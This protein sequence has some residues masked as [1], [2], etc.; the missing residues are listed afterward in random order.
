MLEFYGDG[1]LY[2]PIL[3]RKPL[4]GDQIIDAWEH[5]DPVFREQR[6]ICFV[7]GVRFAEKHHG[8]GGGDE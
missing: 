2:P 8:I 3:E 7:Q 5:L 1:T 6:L 4:D